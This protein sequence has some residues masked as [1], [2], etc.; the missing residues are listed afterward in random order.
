M[1]RYKASGMFEMAVWG[2]SEHE[3]RQTVEQLLAKIGVRC[4]V[5]T[6]ETVDGG[7]G[8]CQDARQGT[9]GL[10]KPTCG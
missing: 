9:K 3:A 10:D 4:C 7:G 1:R 8:G 5:I 6:V 2:E